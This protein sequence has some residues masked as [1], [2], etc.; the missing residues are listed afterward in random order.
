MA[1]RPASH[2]IL[3]VVVALLA[4]ATPSSTAAADPSRAYRSGPAEHCVTH[5]EQVEEGGPAARVISEICFGTFADAISQATDGLMVVA[6]DAR[7]ESLTQS[8]LSEAGTS[9]SYVLGIDY[10]NWH[11]SQTKGSK[12]GLLAPV[13]TQGTGML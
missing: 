12:I 13:V 3:P 5:I 4:L 1:S 6:Q 2:R 9:S 7:P 11:Y 10:D 8:M